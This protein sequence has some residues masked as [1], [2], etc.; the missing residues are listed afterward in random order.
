MPKQTPMLL[1]YRQA[2]S[3]LLQGLDNCL[4]CIITFLMLKFS[5]VPI[6]HCGTFKASFTTFAA[7]IP[8]S[9]FKVL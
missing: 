3:P 5:T 1:R 4:R 7:F 8:I 6:T 9:A 2:T